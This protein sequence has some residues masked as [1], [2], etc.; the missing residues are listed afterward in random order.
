[1]LEGS[2]APPGEV[3]EQRDRMLAGFRW[4]LVDEYQDIKELEYNLISAL[5]GRT[6]T[7]QDM[8]LNLFAVGDDDQNIYAFSGSSSQ[9]IKRFEDD[10][11]ARPSYLTENYR[12][13]G[14]IISAA[15]SVIEPA[16][17][18]MKVEP[19]HNREPKPGPGTSRRRVGT[20]RSGDPG[21][22]PDTP[23]RG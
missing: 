20:D 12:S 7:D 9:Y 13:T 17:V 8:R 5:A 3:D 16:N 14:H 19:P 4:I 15:N 23:G 11:R 1:M 10:Y 2:N 6:K 18:R 22:G 21:E